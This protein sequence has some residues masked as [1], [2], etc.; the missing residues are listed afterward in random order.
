MAASV[1]M[2]VTAAMPTEV[3]A[4]RSTSVYLNQMR[5]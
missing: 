5:W 3:G 4:G 1:A 2:V